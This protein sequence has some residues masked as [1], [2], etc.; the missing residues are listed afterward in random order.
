MGY[1]VGLGQVTACRQE[2]ILPTSLLK[3]VFCRHDDGLL[4]LY[5]QMVETGIRCCEETH[6]IV[7]DLIVS[8]CTGEIG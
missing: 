2:G 8:N 5:A 6:K 4:K 3:Q 1:M 7:R